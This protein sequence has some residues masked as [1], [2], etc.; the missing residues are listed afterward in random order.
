MKHY[1]PQRVYTTLQDDES[2]KGVVTIPRDAI[3][4]RLER[5]ADSDEGWLT[6]HI[7]GNTMDAPPAAK[8]VVSLDRAHAVIDGNPRLRTRN[9]ITVWCKC[10]H[11]R[12]MTETQ[13]L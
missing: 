13:C 3:L 5:H 12:S 1:S 4:I 8:A 9:Y 10:R 7:T 6:A 11:N 2:V